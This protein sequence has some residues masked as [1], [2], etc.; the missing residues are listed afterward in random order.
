MLLWG[1]QARSELNPRLKTFGVSS[2]GYFVCGQSYKNLLLAQIYASSGPV[3]GVNLDY[4]RL[5][6][7]S[8]ACLQEK[9][10]DAWDG[11]SG[12]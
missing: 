7:K 8:D 12:V 1:I 6:S 4:F 10:S 3:D 5:L 2:F 11:F 9:L